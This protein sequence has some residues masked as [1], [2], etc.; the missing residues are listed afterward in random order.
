MS[1]LAGLLHVHVR[2][3]QSW[4]KR[5]MTPIDP[6]DRP[7]LFIGSEIQRYLSREQK[8]RKCPLKEDEFYC[9]RCRRGRNSHPAEVHLVD[10]GRKMG[11]TDIQVQIKGMCQS[12]EC[13]MTLFSTRRR[14][15][16]SVWQRKLRQGQA[17]LCR[18]R[19]ATVNTDLEG[20]DCGTD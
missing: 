2:T 13:P 8:A 5:G 3:V 17:R 12:C 9:P 14:V 15:A 11:R 10:A 4:R 16:E 20:G 7:W 19:K 1:E 18:D 6:D